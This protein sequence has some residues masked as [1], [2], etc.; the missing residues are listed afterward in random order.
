MTKQTQ[1]NH[2]NL[3]SIAKF[4]QFTLLFFL[5]LIVFNRLLFKLYEAIYK[6]LFLNDIGVF[7]ILVV[8]FTVLFWELNGQIKGKKQVSW[9]L[10][11]AFIA[12]AVIK[13]MWLIIYA[14]IT[15]SFVPL[16]Y[17]KFLDYSVYQWVSTNAFKN[18]HLI[19]AFVF[20]AGIY[21]ALKYYH[22]VS[23]AMQINGVQKDKKDSFELNDDRTLGETESFQN[24]TTLEELKEQ[25]KLGR[26]DYAQQISHI[27]INNGEKKSFAIGIN[28]EWGSGKTSF[29]DMIKG[30]NEIEYRK[31]CIFINFNPWYFTGTEKVLKKFY[32]TLI[33]AVDN[34]FSI[35]FRNDLSKYFELI[36][37]TESKIWKTNFLQY[38]KKN[39]DFESQLDDLKEHFK[40]L[41][42]KIVIIIDDLDRL[43]K[44]E[45]LVLFRTIRLIADFPNM[46][47]LVGYSH[48]H[49]NDM[50]RESHVTKEEQASFME[51]I[52]QLEFELPEPIPNDLKVFWKSIIANFIP[53]DTSGLQMGIINKIVDN[54]ILP[55]LRDIKRFINQLSI[56]SSLPEVKNNTYQPQFFLLELIF[57]YDSEAHYTIRKSRSLDIKTYQNSDKKID[58]GTIKLIEQIKKLDK[59]TT[60]SIVDPKHFDKYFF[61]RLDRQRDIDFHEVKSLFSDPNYEKEFRILYH[62]SDVS[63]MQIIDHILRFTESFENNPDEFEKAKWKQY[64]DRIFFLFEYIYTSE[65]Y[66]KNYFKKGASVREQRLIKGISIICKLISTGNCSNE[67][68]YFQSKLDNKSFSDFLLIFAEENKELHPIFYKIS[69]LFRDKIRDEVEI[70][71]TDTMC[72]IISLYNYSKFLKLGKYGDYIYSDEAI[73]N[74]LRERAEM[75]YSDIKQLNKD[76]KVS[77]LDVFGSKENL[78]KLNDMKTEGVFNL[79][80][81]ERFH[82]PVV[83]EMECHKFNYSFTFDPYNYRIKIP[84]SLTKILIVSENEKGLTHDI[85]KLADGAYEYWNKIN[86]SQKRFQKRFYLNKEIRFLELFKHDEG[87]FFYLFDGHIQRQKAPILSDT[88]ST[89]PYSSF[90]IIIET[91][92][93]ERFVLERQVISDNILPELL[94]NEPTK[95]ELLTK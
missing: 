38:F 84:T 21:L 34:N 59:N 69:E 7:L 44:D 60:Q 68:A 4:W 76:K 37:A 45:I 75:L 10:R 77:L 71:S 13:S 1:A 28:G 61:K 56:N 89:D 42:Q 23:M 43:Q 19:I 79:L 49:V 12:A 91:E 47:Y 94:N 9:K 66:D 40:G 27:I 73:L 86:D 95:D 58:E 46:V 87:V 88:I 53:A 52:F 30:I 92:K 35:T 31:Q 55:N 62:I 16:S 8:V 36:C 48:K 22:W 78:L 17:F 81:N 54:N 6:A 32:D 14:F 90:K 39:T 65:R 83:E 29:I 18:I 64:L 50:I 26:F 82:Y 93:A 67:V 85:F 74:G 11:D 15:L 63:Q 41:P 72:T 2:M 5:A 20:C 25:D 80:D 57:Y 70:H 51:K 3:K 24:C 33:N